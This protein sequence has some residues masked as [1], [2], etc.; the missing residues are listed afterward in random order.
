MP[1]Q[2]GNILIPMP[3]HVNEIQHIC[4]DLTLEKLGAETKFNFAQHANARAV[5]QRCATLLSRQAVSLHCTALQSG[6]AY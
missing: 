2:H 4:Y 3:L 1:R 5:G 6:S